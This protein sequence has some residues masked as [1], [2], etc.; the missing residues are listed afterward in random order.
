MSHERAAHT[1]E[2]FF[3]GHRAVRG[4]IRES[5]VTIA[6]LRLGTYTPEVT[7]FDALEDTYLYA[8]LIARALSTATI[9]TITDIGAGS[10]IPTL[11]AIRSVGGWNGRV[12]ASDVDAAALDVSRRNAEK[13]GSLAQYAFQHA[14]LFDVLPHLVTG[15]GHLIAANLPYLPIP[16][17]SAGPDMMTVNGG[18]DGT[19][20]L[21]PL[22]AHPMEQG[23][24]VALQWSSLSDPV[25]VMRCIERSYAVLSVTAHQTPF[26]MY[27]NA[28]PIRA[29]LEQQRR[30]GRAVFSTNKAGEH[31]YMFLGTIL[32]RC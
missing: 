14:S 22:L 10:S 1:L 4:A 31:A 25:A 18:P 9:H 16:L 8:Q 13:T 28:N 12:E 6:H 24:L 11:W 15:P 30:E 3:T 29:H 27:T 2:E 7:K 20:Y 21:L 26:G 19:Q 17:P 32:Q 5:D 23:T